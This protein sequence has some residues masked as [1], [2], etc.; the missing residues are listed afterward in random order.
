[1]PT[2]KTYRIFVSHAWTYTYEYYRFLGILDQAPNFYYHNYSVPDH[3]PLHAKSRRE[4]QQA[5]YDQ[6][7]PTNIV[8]I[9]AGM[10]VSYSQWIQK[11]IDISLA[12]GKPIL[13]VRPL[14]NQRTPRAVWDAADEIVGWRTASIVR[15][16]R[17][18]A[19]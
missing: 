16:I 5:L 18:L 1:M 15:T 10:Y 11:E 2:L 12:M 6:I 14:G 9:L 19:I 3:D 17:E 7:R 4:L 8:I 13:G